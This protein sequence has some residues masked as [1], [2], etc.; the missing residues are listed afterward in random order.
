M[1]PVVHWRRVSPDV[2]VARVGAVLLRAIRAPNQ[3]GFDRPCWRCEAHSERGVKLVGFA[4]QIGSARK[5][6]LQ[7]VRQVE[8]L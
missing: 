4:R 2:H 8:V 3:G 6:L 5:V 1:T 7:Y